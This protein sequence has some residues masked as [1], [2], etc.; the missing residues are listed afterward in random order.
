LKD[1]SKE[2]DM[3]NKKA[4]ELFK[5]QLRK[6]F[7]NKKEAIT[8]EVELFFDGVMKEVYADFSMFTLQP[9]L[10]RLSSHF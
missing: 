5:M 9:D 2:V 4:I 6:L 8:K 7:L 1:K 3:E 10:K